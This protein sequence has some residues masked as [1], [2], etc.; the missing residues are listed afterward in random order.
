[1]FLRYPA[2]QAGAGKF[3]AGIGRQGV[4]FAVAWRAW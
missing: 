4:A 3:Y 1:M 2:R